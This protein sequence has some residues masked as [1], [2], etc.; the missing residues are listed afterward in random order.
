MRNF[1]KGVPLT[2]NGIYQFRV[3]LKEE[4]E[5]KLK[6]FAEVPFDITLKVAPTK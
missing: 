1:I 5:D 6:T 3:M 2:K 4:G